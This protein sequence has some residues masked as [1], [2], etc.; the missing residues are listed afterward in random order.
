VL[1]ALLV[2]LVTVASLP[3]S[4]WGEEPEE[5]S[6]AA[7]SSQ[8]WRIGNSGLWVGG[9]VNNVLTLPEHG[10]DSFTLTDVGLLLR[11]DVTP[12]ITFFNETDLEDSLSWEEGN[13]VVVGTR[14]LLLER[15]YVDWQPR[16]DITLRLGKFLTPFGL[17]NVVRRAPL[18]WTVEAPLIS[19]G[20]FPEHITG[21]A[22]GF[23]TTLREWTIDATGYGQA[24]DELYRGASDTTASS[25]GGGRVSAGHTFGPFYFEL[26]SSGIGFDNSDNN[27][28][29]YSVG[30]DFALTGLG[31]YLQGEVTYGW[32]TGRPDQWGLYLQDALPVPFI[33]NLWAVARY[34]HFVPINAPQLNGAVLGVAWRPLPWLFLKVNYQV[35]DTESDDFDRGLLAGVVI[36]F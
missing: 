3:P 15:L 24:T 28:T 23:Q 36:F 22:A 12:S 16:P 21:A 4:T 11:Y 9:Y 18:T 7:E 5:P 25:A 32:T 2:L 14:V 20:F 29:Q 1:A 8:G 31:N 6:V 26:G 27:R 19:E 30:G 33:K 35:A 34:E 13:G 17:W 10:P